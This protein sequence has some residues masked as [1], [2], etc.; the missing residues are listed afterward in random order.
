MLGYHAAQAHSDSGPGTDII[1]VMES[2]VKTP[3]RLRFSCA[4]SSL[5]YSPKHGCVAVNPPNSPFT[6][7]TGFIVSK[8]SKLGT[9][10]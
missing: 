2:P 10:L 1:Q 7:Q 4:A 5:D 6:E 9:S 8:G 3:A